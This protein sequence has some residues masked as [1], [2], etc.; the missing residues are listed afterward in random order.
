MDGYHFIQN[1]TL[2]EFIEIVKLQGIELVNLPETF[3]LSDEKE[4]S[5]SFFERKI[6]G[7]KPLTYSLPANDF[8]QKLNHRTLRAMC[9]ALQIPMASF[10]LNV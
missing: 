10:G 2:N 3:K 6:D 5:I 8:D 1:P 4:I 7:E 9:N